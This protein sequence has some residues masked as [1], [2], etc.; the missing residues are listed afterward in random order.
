MAPP[1]AS[2]ESGCSLS[3]YL[4][5]ADAEALRARA[6]AGDRSVAAEIRRAIRAYLTDAPSNGESP[7]TTPSSRDNSGVDGTG[8]A[9]PRA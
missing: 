5:P 8:H 1:I 3:T 6:A 9:L 4:A 7:A 2:R